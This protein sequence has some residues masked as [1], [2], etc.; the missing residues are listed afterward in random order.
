MKWAGGGVGQYE[1]R[2]SLCCDAVDGVGMRMQSSAEDNPL[3]DC[4]SEV[5]SLKCKHDIHRSM[6]KF[7]L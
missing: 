7:S 4:L 6:R 2:R 3:C 5:L 1:N